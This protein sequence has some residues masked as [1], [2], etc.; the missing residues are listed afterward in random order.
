MGV[1]HS[2]GIGD[3]GTHV[4]GISAANDVEGSGVVGMAPDAQI[5]VMKVF[6]RSGGAYLYD[7][8]NA[9]EDAMILGCDVANLSL[10]SAALSAGFILSGCPPMAGRR[11]SAP[12]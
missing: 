12:T 3:H 6:S 1:D 9:L 11:L 7:I 2:D 10:G 4:A 8:L 5:V